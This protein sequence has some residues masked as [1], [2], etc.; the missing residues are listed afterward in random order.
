MPYIFLAIMVI[1]VFAIY[2]LYVARTPKDE[3]QKLFKKKEK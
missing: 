1:A 2:R 3:R